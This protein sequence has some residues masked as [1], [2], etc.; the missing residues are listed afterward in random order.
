MAKRV[1][2]GGVV[3][4][5]V[6]RPR[7]FRAQR[8]AAG[9]RRRLNFRQA[10]FVGIERKFADFEAQDDAFA[11][12]WAPME[13]GTIKSISA[14]A[15][16]NTESTRVGR[17]YHITSLHLRGSVE[18]GG[19]EADTAPINDV[20]C[21]FVLVWDTQTNAAQL[22]ATDVMDA[23]QSEDHFAF[24]NLQNTKRFRILMD[25]VIT[26]RMDNQTNEGAVNSFAS[27]QRQVHWKFN[28]TF[29]K[30]IKVIC[31]GT[32]AV[33]GSITDNSIH[34]IGICSTTSASPKLN[35]QARIRFTG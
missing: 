18:T 3:I 2:T 21:R 19:Q 1:R 22:T 7:Q 35:Y 26:V 25:K 9:A 33:I 6:K 32:S 24:R 8:G 10:G 12:S 15:V 5:P 14:V 28:R 29:K 20:M 13:D 16:G 30:P 27:G 4:T 23:G 31:S 34:M 11:T 17:V